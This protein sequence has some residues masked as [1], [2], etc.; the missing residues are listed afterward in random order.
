MFA[1]TAA[2]QIAISTIVLLIL[3]GIILAGMVATFA[4]VFGLGGR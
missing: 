1:I 3:I 4:L 2:A